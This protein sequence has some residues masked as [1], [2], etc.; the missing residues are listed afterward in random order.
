M[1]VD[2]EVEDKWS[3]QAPRGNLMEHGR[4]HALS[5]DECPRNRHSESGPPRASIQPSAANHSVA[6][7]TVWGKQ[8]HNDYLNATTGVLRVRDDA[9]R[10]WNGKDADLYR[11]NRVSAFDEYR[12]ERITRDFEKR[13]RH[14]YAKASVMKKRTRLR[15]PVLSKGRHREERRQAPKEGRGRKTTD[16]IS[17]SAEAQRGCFPFPP[18]RSAETGREGRK[19]RKKDEIRYKNSGQEA[20]ASEGESPP[21]WRKLGWDIDHHTTQHLFLSAGEASKKSAQRSTSTNPSHPAPIAS[22]RH[23]QRQHT[24]PTHP[25]PRWDTRAR[26]RGGA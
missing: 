8:T 9:Q 14:C 5:Y 11:N 10:K 7:H 18:R 25:H 21:S 12:K 26:H 23:T 15:S 20:R 16:D 2:L 3:P 13:K 22:P 19:G 1:P 6:K 17:Q 24:R 4:Q